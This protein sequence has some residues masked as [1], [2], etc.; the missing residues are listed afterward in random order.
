MRGGRATAGRDHPPTGNP[1]EP[2]EDLGRAGPAFSTETPAE[3]PEQ[4]HKGATDETAAQAH[5]R[6]L[7]RLRQGVG[8]LAAPPPGPRARR[9]EPDGAGGV[10]SPAGEGGRPG[11]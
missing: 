10:G 3:P 9:G 11:A 4:A 5:Y 2:E 7:P 6:L 1:G 8:R